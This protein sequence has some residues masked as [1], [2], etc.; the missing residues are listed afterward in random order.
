M[1]RLKQCL[2]DSPKGKHVVFGRVI[3][4]YDEVVKKLA[5]VPVDLKDRPTIPVVISRCGELEL[6]SRPSDV[7][8]GSSR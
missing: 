5:E 1:N 4:G 8:E 6:R 3:R 2:I 7:P